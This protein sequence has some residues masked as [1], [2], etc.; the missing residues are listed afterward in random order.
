MYNT[1]VINPAYAG[2]RGL[3]S[4]S[5]LYRTQWVG[6]EGAP[7]TLNFSLNSPLGKKGIGIGLAII[8]DKIG[9]S[10]ENNLTLDVSYTIPLSQNTR[11][12][13]GIKGGIN[14]LNVDYSKLNIFNPADP[15]FSSNIRDRLSPL[16]GS[17]VYLHH[18]ERWYLGLSS[19]NFLNTTHYDD[20]ASSTAT[21]RIHLYGIAGYVFDIN[22][23]IKLKPAALAKMVPGAPLS[24]DFS[25]NVL[26]FDK[27]TLG[28]A[29]R[30][31]AAGSF[32]AGFQISDQ[33]MIGYAYDYDTTALSHYNSG[34]H[35]IFL[36]FEL[37]TR[38][39]KTV[40]PRFF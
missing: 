13:F 28:A 19:P 33:L 29:H 24:M 7:E 11:L 9:P 25:M 37:T 2:N 3:L 38:V 30:L 26:C 5:G 8:S 34:S 14:L 20:I 40:N 35:E 16:I 21:E 4:I 23:T 15:D 39:R 10:S 27:L 22:N 32:L 6:L 36:R 1:Q 18:K 31:D 12:S 17:G